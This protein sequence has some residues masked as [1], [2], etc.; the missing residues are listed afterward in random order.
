LRTQ[1]VISRFARLISICTALTHLKVFSGLWRCLLTQENAALVASA[2]STC[3]LL[4]HLNLYGF[5]MN[6]QNMELITQALEQCKD[7]I[8]VN[9]GGNRIDCRGVEQL[10]KALQG[11]NNLQSLKFFGNCIRASGFKALTT[12][13]AK[14]WPRIKHLNLAGNPIGPPTNAAVN[15][16]RH[17]SALSLELLD[18]RACMIHNAG[19]AALA[20]VIPQLQNLK[21]L[22]VSSNKIASPGIDPLASSIIHCSQLAHLDL[23]SN[24]V[25]VTGAQTLAA[26]L[27]HL[28]ALKY[29]NLF[30][31]KLGDVG[32]GALAAVEAELSSLEILDLRQNNISD[33][34]AALLAGL[35]VNAPN[36]KLVDLTKNLS[37]SRSDGR[38][39]FSELELKFAGGRDGAGLK[40]LVNAMP[41]CCVQAHKSRSKRENGGRVLRRA[42]ACWRVVWSAPRDLSCLATCWGTWLVR[43]EE[44][45]EAR[46]FLLPSP[47]A[48]SLFEED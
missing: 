21:H 22:D 29:L 48:H 16:Q 10:A 20:A 27:P 25:G 3:K 32:V 1:G 12:Q 4:T 30:R 34:G 7:L 44:W 24:Y 8:S 33:V 31:T 14:S 36:I 15:F 42:G 38:G 13:I 47:R 46:P 40:L 18:L 35:V 41:C 19:A 11:C 45:K 6:F 37:R 2:L 43:K 17:S 5:G 28:R 9:F 39:H 23:S 26:S